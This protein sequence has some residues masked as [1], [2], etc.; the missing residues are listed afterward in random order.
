MPY[1]ITCCICK[2]VINHESKFLICQPTVL[3]D[4]EWKRVRWGKWKQFSMCPKCLNHV[5]EGRKTNGN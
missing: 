5:I 2:E 1:R 4:G 3:I